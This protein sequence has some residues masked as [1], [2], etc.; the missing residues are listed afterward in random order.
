MQLLLQRGS[1]GPLINTC[2]NV[3]VGC[4]WANQSYQAQ[5]PV[6]PGPAVLVN[7]A[8]A[9]VLGEQRQLWSRVLEIHAAP[10]DLQLTDQATIHSYVTT[11]MK[12]ILPLAL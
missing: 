12:V 3:E 2:Q 11:G 8:S 4:P 6:L 5:Q 1:P 10:G 9:P 7:W